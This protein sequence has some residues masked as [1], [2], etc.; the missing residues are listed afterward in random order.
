MKIDLHRLRFTLAALTVSSLNLFAMPAMAAPEEIQVYLDEFAELGKFGLDLHTTYVASTRNGYGG[1]PQHQLRLTPELSYG[2][3]KNIETAAYFLTNKAPGYPI[4][5]DGVKI[6]FRY[7]PVVPT[8]ETTWYTAVN[9]EL[10]KLSRRFNSDYSNGEIKAILSWRSGPW[11]VG[12][13]INLDRA[14][15]RSS[16][17]PATFEID[18]KIMHAVTKQF[19]IGLERYDFLGSLHGSVSGPGPSHTTFL[20]TDFSAGKWDVNFGV[21]RAKGDIVEKT[22]VKAIVGIPI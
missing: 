2:L 9:I 17:L 5:S 10:G 15:R 12:T 16:A 11:V 7:R 6:R 8:D 13:N 1:L 18:S 21:G 3:T 19:S 22:I 4:Q 14:L 20:S